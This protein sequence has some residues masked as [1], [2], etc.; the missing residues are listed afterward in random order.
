MTLDKVEGGLGAQPE[1]NHKTEQR[2][3]FR[4]CCYKVIKFTVKESLNC[5]FYGSIA[6][7]AIGIFAAIPA[8][9]TISAASII[10]TLGMGTIGVIAVSTVSIAFFFLLRAI[11]S[12]K[13]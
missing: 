3:S 2:G 7:L 8:T 1:G 11:A 4:G 5:L 10:A 12:E 13:L 9:A 6:A